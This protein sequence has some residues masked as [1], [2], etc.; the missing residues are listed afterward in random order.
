MYS[1]AIQILESTNQGDEGSIDA[2]T[3]SLCSH[4]QGPES[5][6]SHLIAGNF[7]HLDVCEKSFSHSLPH[8]SAYIDEDT[9]QSLTNHRW[10]Y[11]KKVHAGYLQNGAT[12]LGVSP[13]EVSFIKPFFRKV[14]WLAQ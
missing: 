9:G 10:R 1:C 13:N 14:S 7:H 4:V 5:R 2:T 12:F 6:L 11:Y 8:I 3:A